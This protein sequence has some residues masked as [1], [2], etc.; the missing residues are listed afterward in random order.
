VTNSTLT[1]SN[2][3]FEENMA[4]ESGVLFATDY[5]II[6]ISNTQFRF[7]RAISIGV[8]KITS[9]SILSVSGSGFY[10][11]EAW[12]GK[13]VGLILESHQSTFY[14][15]TFRENRMVT[16]SGMALFELLY[17]QN[18]TFELC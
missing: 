3:M 11:N 9:D 6:T 1:I 5:S 8:L 16:S 15:C 12:Q 4:F 10:W 2:S 7:N 14:D 18:V 13:S 17:V